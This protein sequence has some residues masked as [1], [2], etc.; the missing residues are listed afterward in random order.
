MVFYLQNHHLAELCRTGKGLV[1]VGYFHWETEPSNFPCDE[2]CPFIADKIIYIQLNLQAFTSKGIIKKFSLVLCTWF[3]FS[4]SCSEIQRMRWG[5]RIQWGIPY[6]KQD[7][8]FWLA[9]PINTS[10]ICIRGY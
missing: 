5:K 7:C 6:L 9:K 3:G 8:L 10:V 4:H 1:N 2:V